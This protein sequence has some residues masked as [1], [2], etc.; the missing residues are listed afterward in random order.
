MLFLTIKNLVIELMIVDKPVCK[1]LD[2]RLLW[3]TANGLGSISSIW[4]KFCLI[5]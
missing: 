3:I 1:H 4:V 2:I 5:C